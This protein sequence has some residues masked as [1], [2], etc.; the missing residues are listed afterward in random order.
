MSA[1]VMPIRNTVS[2]AAMCGNAK[3]DAM[4]SIRNVVAVR[5]FADFSVR[6]VVS[7]FS[8][9]LI[10]SYAILCNSCANGENHSLNYPLAAQ[11]V[12]VRHQQRTKCLIWHQACLR[13]PRKLPP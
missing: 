4:V 13:E 9:S 12:A 1:A 6:I 2:A 7:S 3:A 8:T 10:N 5:L 11:L